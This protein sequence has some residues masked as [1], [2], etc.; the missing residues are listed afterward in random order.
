MKVQQNGKTM[1]LQKSEYMATIFD[2]HSH[3]ERRVF[4]D[5]QGTRYVRINGWFA[6][7]VDLRM[8]NHFDVDTFYDGGGRF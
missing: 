4:V 5:E 2:G 7:L 3:I 8:V 6:R 1:V